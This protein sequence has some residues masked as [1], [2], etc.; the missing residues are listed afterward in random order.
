METPAQKGLW[1]YLAVPMVAILLCGSKEP[2]ALGVFALLVG[3]TALIAT[4]K[5]SV[6]RRVSLPLLGAL[7]LGLGAFL[8]AS[9][10]ALPEWRV[11]LDRDFGIAM[12]GT[13]SPQ[14][15]ITLES[16]V[17]L[18]VGAAWLFFCL[19]RGFSSAERRHAL[20]IM[21]V[22]MAVLACAAMAVSALKIDIP[23]WRGV[24]KEWFFGPFPN[25]NNFSGI[26]AIGVLLGLAVTHDAFRHRQPRWWLYLLAIVPVFV[27]VLSN[28][29]RM[30]VVALFIGAGAWMF[31]AS[32]SRESVKRAAIFFTVLVTMAAAVI[33]FG[34]QLVSRFTGGDE[35]MVASLAKDSRWQMF[36]DAGNL[37]MGSPGLGVGLGNFEPVFAMTRTA[38]ELHSR[39]IHPENDWLWFGAETGLVAL[40]LAVFAA[41]SLIVLFHLRLAPEGQSMRDKRM[42]SAAGIGVLLMALEGLVNTPMHAPGFFAFGSLLAGLAPAPRA[43][44]PALPPVS[45]LPRKAAGLVCVLC[46]MLWFISVSGNLPIFG[47]SHYRLLAKRASA[48]SAEGDLSGTLQTWDQAAAIKPLQWNIYFERAVLKLRLGRPH[49]DALWDFSCWRQLERSNADFCANEFDIWLDYNPVYGVAALREAMKRDPASASTYFGHRTWRVEAYPALRPHFFAIAASDPKLTLAYL[50][51]ASPSEFNWLLNAL[52]GQH[53]TLAVFTPQEKLRTFQIW[54]EK[55]DVAKLIRML[56]DNLEWRREGWTV[57][58]TQKAKEGDFQGAYDLAMHHVRV[59]TKLGSAS[60]EADKVPDLAKKFDRNPAD[61][62]QGFVLYEAQRKHD[63]DDEARATL[64][65]LAQL[66]TVPARVYFERATLFAEKSDYTRAWEGII[67]YYRRTEADQNAKDGN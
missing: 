44:A 19:G 67:E 43:P 30:G 60:V 4:P 2:W 64:E 16:W 8:P 27:A 50:Q 42:R 35:G 7:L 32:L 34:R 45:L 66:P 48:L 17:A 53:P 14:P 18:A 20:R 23:F 10:S 57:L 38:G 24:S 49:G 3:L 52:L 26:L 21:T 29:S 65:R 51:Y 40:L 22:F 28:S 31:T 46:G 47:N 36:Q 1:L 54:S 33:L 39:A 56:E 15:W 41:W 9:W 13:R 63:R 59:P 25:R 55:G 37:I 5:Q 61:I 62:L 12:A 6:S 11:I 58:A